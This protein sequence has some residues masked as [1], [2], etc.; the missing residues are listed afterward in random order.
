MEKEVVGIINA[1]SNLVAQFDRHPVGGGMFLCCFSMLLLV[2]AV[3]IL[4]RPRSTDATS[5]GEKA[6]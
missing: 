3:F 1:C 5:R 4:T 6:L 2:V